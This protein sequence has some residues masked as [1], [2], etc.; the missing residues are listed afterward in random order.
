MPETFLQAGD[1]V[2]ALGHYSSR[3]KAIGKDMTARFAHVWRLDDGKPARL[4]HYADTLQLARAL[5]RL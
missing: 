3:A 4:P 5:D 1:H 2:I